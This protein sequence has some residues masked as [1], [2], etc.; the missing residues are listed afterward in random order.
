MAAGPCWVAAAAPRQRPGPAVAVF[1]IVLIV[2][3]ISGWT[4]DVYAGVG[5]LV[6]WLMTLARSRHTRHI[7]RTSHARTPEPSL[8]RR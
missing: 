7:N 8:R 2:S 4:L 6:L 5:L 3:G 1:E